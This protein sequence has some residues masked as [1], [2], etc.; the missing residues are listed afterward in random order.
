MAHHGSA[1]GSAGARV[2]VPD[3]PQ[4]IT[5]IGRRQLTV[6]FFNS[7]TKNAATAIAGRRDQDRDA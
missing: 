6:P 2:H 7:E 1:D 3:Y 4:A 5:R